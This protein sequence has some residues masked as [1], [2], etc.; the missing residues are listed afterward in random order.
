M[1]QKVIACQSVDH[2]KQL[3]DGHPW[4]FLNFWAPWAEPC[5]HMNQV[6]EELAGKQSANFLRTTGAFIQARALHENHDSDF[7][8]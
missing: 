6:F 5:A 3:S 1:T 4:L 2:F 8:K 7:W